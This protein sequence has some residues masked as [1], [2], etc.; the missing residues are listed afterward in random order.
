MKK[1]RRCDDHDEWRILRLEHKHTWQRDRGKRIQSFSSLPRL[2]YPRLSL[3]FSFSLPLPTS[4]YG[5]SGHIDEEEIDAGLW[6]PHL[7]KRRKEG[8]KGEQRKSEGGDE[9]EGIKEVFMS[10]FS[11]H[12]NCTQFIASSEGLYFFN[13]RH[14][15]FSLRFR[16]LLPLTI[17]SDGAMYS[18]L[19]HISS[20][21]SPRSTISRRIGS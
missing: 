16:P 21:R 6:W 13:P 10:F 9:K 2:F 4:A 5:V 18:T 19:A 3:S 1:K 11:L 14:S 17:Y 8:G 15:H 12:N 7:I 20:A